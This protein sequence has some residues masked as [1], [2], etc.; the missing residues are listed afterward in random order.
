MRKRNIF[1]LCA[2]TFL[3]GMV[4]YAAVATLYRQAAGL[5]VFEITAIEGVSVAL[6]LALEIPWGWAADRLGYRRVMVLCNALFLVTKVIFWR[7]ETF[8]GFLAE[9]L[10]L[11]VVISGL[12]GVDASML[13]L[14]A[15]PR[16]AQRNSGWYYAAGEA[17]VLL[18][19]LLYTAFLSGQYRQTALWTVV[20][21][22]VAAVLTLFLQEVRPREARRQ[23]EPLGR[24]ARAH[25]RVPGMLALVVCAAL[26]SEA[27]HCVTLYFSQLQYLRCGLG[28]RAI[29]AAFL[30]ASLAGLCGP[31][32]AR[33]TRRMG[34]RRMG[35]GLLLLAALCMGALALTRSG[36]LSVLLIALLTALAALFAPLTA[37]R[38]N[39]LVVTDDRATALSLNAMVGDS[40]IVLVDMG[41][42]RAADA[43]LPLALGLGGMGCLVAMGI[44]GAMRAGSPPRNFFFPD[45]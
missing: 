38:E 21:Y 31:L 42:G 35:M 16:D 19:G 30:A 1:L 5:S 18:S 6:S 15:P 24:L 14:S 2:I 27:V 29:G 36:P 10:L 33:I 44:W 40:L 12:S 34:Q 28:D 25:F 39:A 26:F 7:A 3:Q 37:A 13:Y 23:R 11:A 9:R 45:N 22:A 8:M 41:L 4:F 43:S 17:G 32:S 20:T